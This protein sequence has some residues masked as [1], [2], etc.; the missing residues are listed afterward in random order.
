VLKKVTGKYADC[1]EGQLNIRY[2]TVAICD[3]T[4]REYVPPSL[5]RARKLAQKKEVTR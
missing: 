5:L 3:V 4:P 1:D 2:V